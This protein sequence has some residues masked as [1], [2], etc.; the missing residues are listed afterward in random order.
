MVIPR[1]QHEFNRIPQSVHNSVQ[2]CVQPASGSPNCLICRFSP[3]VGTFVNLDVGRVQAQVFHIRIC[4]QCAKYGFQCTI[5]PPFGESGIYRLPGT[6]CL[7]QFPPLR[8]AA[9]DPDSASSGHLSEDGSVSPSFPAVTALLCAP[10]VLFSIH[11]VSYPYFCTNAHFVQYLFFKHALMIKH[12]VGVS[13]EH[14]YEVKKW[15]VISFPKNYDICVFRSGDFIFIVKSPLTNVLLR[16]L[17]LL[18]KPLNV[19]SRW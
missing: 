6:I 17:R 9:G 7:W 4:G 10:I 19:Q 5:V 14:I 2:L 3:S 1:R 18:Q 15:T 12:N 11:I 13:V 8:T 16:R